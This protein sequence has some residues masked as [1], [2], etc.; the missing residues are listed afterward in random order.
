MFFIIS[1]SG[2]EV[3]HLNLNRQGYKKFN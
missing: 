2:N 3:I 1:D